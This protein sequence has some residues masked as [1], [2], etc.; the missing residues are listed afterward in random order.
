MPDLAILAKKGAYVILSRILTLVDS[1]KRRASAVASLCM[2]EWTSA[3]GLEPMISRYL[4]LTALW[5]P[6]FLSAKRTPSPDTLLELAKF[7]D[8]VQSHDKV[9]IARRVDIARHWHRTFPV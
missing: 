3:V 2:W 9:W 6:A 4:T 1:T 7:L 8:H 5:G